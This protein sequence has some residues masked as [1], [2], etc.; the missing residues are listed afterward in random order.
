M[1]DIE[2]ERE[3]DDEQTQVD[4]LNNP[5]VKQAQQVNNKI[6]DVI[7]RHIQNIEF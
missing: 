4:F 1:D 7:H 6:I 2:Q 3:S 5:P